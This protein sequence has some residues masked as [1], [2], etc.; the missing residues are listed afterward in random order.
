MYS[1][2]VFATACHSVALDQATLSVLRPTRNDVHSDGR[3]TPPETCDR[4]VARVMRMAQLGVQSGLD[5]ASMGGV[6]FSER[7][8]ALITEVCNADDYGRLSAVVG[9]HLLSDPRIDCLRSAPTESPMTLSRLLTLY[10]AFVPDLLFT[11]EGH[12][13]FR[14]AL[15]THWRAQGQHTGRLYRV[16]P[17]SRRVC[18]SGVIAT[19]ETNGGRP[20][21]QANWDTQSFCDQIGLRPALIRK[22]MSGRMTCLAL[23]SHFVRPGLACL[24]FPT[25]G[26]P[27]WITWKRFM[28]PIS[29]RRPVATYELL[30]TRRAFDQRAVPT[31]Y[32][33]SLERRL[34][35]R[36]LASAGILGPFHIVAHSLGAVLAL[37]YAVENP[38]QVKSLTLIEP[39]LPWLLRASGTMSQELLDYE[40][41]K[42]STYSTRMTEDQYAIVVRE[43]YGDPAYEPTLS[44][45]WLMMLACMRNIEYRPAA[46]HHANRLDTLRSLRAPMLVICGSRPDAFHQAVVEALT[47]TVDDLRTLELPGGHVPHF[48]AGY[49]SFLAALHEFHSNIQ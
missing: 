19:G 39:G 11:I 6:T 47:N 43:S 33:V 1:T 44:P 12:E 13:R 34:L 23:R 8:T 20:F 15:F 26:L 16:A 45:R 21:S 30:A 28:E 36:T 46:W 2:V 27:G 5:H 18:M 24:L 37:D 17:S 38:N 42:L 49:D 9:T 41:R 35:E 3:A 10:K 22:A 25:F 48:G 4:Y 31:G 40:N 32:S 29:H 14:D 7:A